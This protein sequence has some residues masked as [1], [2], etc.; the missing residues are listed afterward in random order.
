[1]LAQAQAHY[2]KTMPKMTCPMDLTDDEFVDGQ[3]AVA[4]GWYAR[5]NADG[6]TVD[7]G[8][9]SG[10]FADLTP[11]EAERLAKQLLDAAKKARGGFKLRKLGTL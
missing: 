10:S 11:Q 9:E 7:I 3:S 2:N 1:M 8:A 4:E 5:P 6:H